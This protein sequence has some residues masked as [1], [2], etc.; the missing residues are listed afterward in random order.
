MK[1]IK[2][3]YPLPEIGQVF[4]DWTV[5]NNTVKSEKSTRYGKYVTVECVCGRTK[6]ARVSNLVRQETTKCI[7]C[8]A[9][10]RSKNYFKGV[11]EMSQSFFYHLQKGAESRQLE[12]SITKEYLWDLFLKQ[13]RKCSLSG[14]DLVFYTH[15]KNKTE[16]TASVDRIDSS[17]GYTE[18]NVQWVHKHVNLMK[19]NFSQ[20]AFVDL[21][22]LISKHKSASPRIRIITKTQVEGIH[23]WRKCP[24]EEVSY[25]RN[26]HRHI[27][28]IEAKAYVDHGDRDI[29]FIKL[30]HDI[31]TYLTEK[32]YSEIYK[33][34]FFDDCSCEM[35]ADEIIKRFDLYECQ[36]SE[37]FEGGAIVR[38]I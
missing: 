26:Y 33:C 17:K 20:N 7:S 6:D 18:D 38:S 28:H 24:I 15:Y 5:I 8:A 14:L 35:I 32:Y 2:G 9:K 11:G 34:L 13:K 25:L 22:E 37:D 16:Q 27:F 29:E 36:V 1:K 19:L 10:Q 21:C 4:G 12:F 30:S 31:K 23:R 3:K